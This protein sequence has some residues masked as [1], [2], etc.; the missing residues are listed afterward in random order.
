[1][2]GDLRAG[3]GYCWWCLGTSEVFGPG[4]NRQDCPL[5]DGTGSDN[6]VSAQ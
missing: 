6:G 2:P 3:P 5:C 1:M 4:R